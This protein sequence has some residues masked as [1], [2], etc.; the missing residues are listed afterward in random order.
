MPPDSLRRGQIFLLSLNL[1]QVLLLLK[2]KLLR[3]LRR[4]MILE[5]FV[6][7]E[8][9]QVDLHW[10]VLSGAILVDEQLDIGL[11]ADEL[12]L[13][14]DHFRL[15]RDLLA[16]GTQVLH[17]LFQVVLHEVYAGFFKLLKLL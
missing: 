11:G 16:Q 6:W 12:R 10:H 13:L 8:S 3:Q 5:V 9:L 4:H 7:I 15:G 17:H 1:G 14:L 2:L